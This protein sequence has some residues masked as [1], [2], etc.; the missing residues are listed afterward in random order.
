MFGRFD[1]KIRRPVSVGTTVS[2]FA[3][4][5]ATTNGVLPSKEALKRILGAR[6]TG[7]CRKCGE[8]ES[9]LHELC[10]CPALSGPKISQQIISNILAL[11]LCKINVRNVSSVVDPFSNFCSV[12]KYLNSDRIKFLIIFKGMLEKIFYRSEIGDFVVFT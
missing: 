8:E 3:R 9:S 2:E 4:G 7:T 5:G 11:S 1:K 12:E 10:C 6:E